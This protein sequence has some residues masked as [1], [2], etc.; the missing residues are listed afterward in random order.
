MRVE[1]RGRGREPMHH[2]GAKVAEKKEQTQGT[3]GWLPERAG[4]AACIQLVT[5]TIG[6]IASVCGGASSRRA[7]FLTPGRVTKYGK[8]IGGGV[9]LEPD[10]FVKRALK[11]VLK[12]LGFDGGPTLFGTETQ[13]YSI[14]SGRPWLYDRNGSAMSMPKTTMSYT[15]LVTADDVRVANQLG[16]LPD[17]EFF[18]Q[19]LPKLSP[20]ADTASELISEAV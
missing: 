8:Q 4:E 14:R 9:R 2:R 20:E 18:A 11:P 10:N 6:A 17:K 15:H 19:D 12:E 7:L 5:N 13:R 16:V 1:C 3:H